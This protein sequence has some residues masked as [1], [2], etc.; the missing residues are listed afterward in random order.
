MRFCLLSL[1]LPALLA[2]GV[3]FTPADLERVNATAAEYSWASAAKANIL[4][5][6]DSFPQG[7]LDRFGL[8]ELALP[9]EGGQWWHWYV[10]PGQGT[11]LRF[12]PPDRHVCPVDNKRV[13][14][15]PYDQVVY[16]TRHDELANAARDLG[17]AYRLT[18]QR[19]Y[20]ERAAWILKQYAGRYL[21][22]PLHDINGKTAKSGARVHAQ[23]LDEAIWLM[24]MCWAYDLVGDTLEAA[25]RAAIET[26]LLRAAVETIERN[27]MGVSNWQSWHNA[28]IGAAGFVLADRAMAARAID[29]KSGLRFQL[30]NS[31]TADGFWYE[32]SA[33]YHFYALDALRQ[34]AEM[35]SRNGVDLWGEARFRQL[36]EAPMRFMLPDG[37]LA[38]FNDATT[39]NLANYAKLYESA[40]RHYGDAVLAGVAA[41]RTRERDALLFGAPVLEG[42]GKATLES[43]VFAESGYAV[44]RSPGNDHTVILKYGPHGGGHGHY[45]K[46]GLVSYARGGVLALDPGTQAYGAPTHDTWDKMTVAHNTMVVDERTQ[47]EATGRLVW[48]DFGEGYRAARAEVATAYRGVRLERTILL[49]DDYALDVL[50]G[51]ATDGTEHQFDWVYH[52]Q[53]VTET[54]LPLTA[55]AKLPRANGYQHLTGNRA[56]ETG[57]SW[58]VRFNGTALGAA[59]YGALY[60]SAATVKGS[61]ETSREQAA[62]GAW[63]GKLSYQ[64]A[65]AGYLL[66]STPTLTAEQPETPPDGLRVMIYGDGSGHRLLLRLNDASDERFVATVGPIDWRGWKQVEVRNPRQWTHYLGNNDGR[67]DL[68]VRNLSVELQQGPASAP[69]EGVL[70]VDDWQLLY[71][72]EPPLM[73]AD[74]EQVSRN[75]RVWMLGV[76]ETTVVTGNGLGP[77]LQKPVAYVMA[78]RRGPRARF[79]GLLEPYGESEAVRAFRQTEDG[80]LVVTGAG[81]E[82]TI[83]WTESGAVYRRD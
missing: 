47:A 3:L 73:A 32:G 82:D 20:A 29:G 71:E 26:H 25:D 46:L 10:C 48:S 37:T 43:T 60:A 81:W 28:A 33:T 44:L 66:Y 78:R 53:G 2:Q 9:P 19:A 22:L 1:G 23:T 12:E 80:A 50:A 14:G 40:Y 15:W 35:A 64:L 67:V 74:F 7:H 17:L 52:N 61:L 45:D 57:E 6:A 41:M 75:V 76:D 39:V 36:F 31:T 27:D 13:T 11:R 63:S 42:A 38:P 21:S 51:E 54:A 58:S 8:T 83:R 4:K 62:T 18:G 56:A 5:A 34:L 68:P 59:A 30:E 77:D 65:G 72:G 70:Y 49:T 24:A 69:R 79:V 55:Y 16:A